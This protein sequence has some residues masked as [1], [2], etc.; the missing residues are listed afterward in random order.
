MSPLFNTLLGTPVK[1]HAV[2]YKNLKVVVCC[3][4]EI[5]YIILRGVFYCFDC[6][7]YKHHRLK[8]LETHLSKMSSSITPS[9]TTA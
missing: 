8:I 7:I 5:A 6:P 4:V 3:G 1:S 2:H 9:Q